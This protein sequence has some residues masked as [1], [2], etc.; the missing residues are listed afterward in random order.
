MKKISFFIFI[1]FVVP[2]VISVAENPKGRLTY[3]DDSDEITVYDFTGKKIDRI[4][5]GYP[6]LIGYGVETGNTA[7]E[8]ELVP[9]GSIIKMKE[10]SFLKIEELMGTKN[11]K[12]NR[13]ALVKGFFRIVASKLFGANYSVKTPSTVLGVRGTDFTVSS[14]PDGETEILIKEGLVDVFNPAT[15][16]VALLGPGDG[17]KVR[18]KVL[19]QMEYE[20]E[21]VRKRIEEFEFLTLAPETVPRRAPKDYYIAFDYFK[22]IEY[23]E[24]REFF[25]GENYF[26]DSDE[27]LEKFRGYYRDEMADFEKRFSK[28]KQSFKDYMLKE[29]EEFKR[30]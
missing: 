18:E 15:G 11:G 24:F 2:G 25:E 17:A 19:D 27:Y 22:D 13:F 7:A 12:S 6:L 20:M 1:I 28:E 23:R 16:E 4:Y 9:N 14:A 8:I 3:F 5:M 26:A 29:W 10:D 30:Y 21:E